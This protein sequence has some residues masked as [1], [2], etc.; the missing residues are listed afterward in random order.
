[1]HT[2]KATTAT[3]INGEIYMSASS[4]Q[5]LTDSIENST[6]DIEEKTAEKEL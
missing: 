6:K 5:D 4:P 1:M 2:S 3:W